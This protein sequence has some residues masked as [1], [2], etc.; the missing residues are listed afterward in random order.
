MTG[1]L[2]SL[3]RESG[4]EEYVLEE[5]SRMSRSRA[6]TARESEILDLVA[7]G[8]PDKE[9]AFRLQISRRTVRTHLERVYHRFD[10]HDR[11]AMAIAWF[12]SGQNKKQT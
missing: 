4:R 1:V 10:V 11:T 5:G 9:I 8:C 12:Q 2:L 7:R 6:F 3:Q